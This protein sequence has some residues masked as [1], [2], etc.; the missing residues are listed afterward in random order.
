MHLGHP[1]ALRRLLGAFH[2]NDAG[3]RDWVS[4]LETRFDLSRRLLLVNPRLGLNANL[5][6]DA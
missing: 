5:F 6:I 1:A 2:D 4:G 3:L